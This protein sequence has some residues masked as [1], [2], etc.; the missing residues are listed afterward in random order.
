MMAP[1]APPVTKF[2]MNSSLTRIIRSSSFLER[3]AAWAQLGTAAL[4]RP[5][6][7]LLL[8][9][10]ILTM[11]GLRIIS[12]ARFEPWD[13]DLI[14]TLQ[15][16]VGMAS[17]ESGVRGPLMVETKAFLE[18]CSQKTGFLSVPKDIMIRLAFC[19]F[20]CQA[21][22]VVYVREIDECLRFETTL[23]NSGED[24]LFFTNLLSSAKNICF[25]LDSTVECGDG[26]NIYYSNLVWDRCLAIKIDIL[27]A[28]KLIGRKIRLS[29]ANVKWYKKKLNACRKEL[30]F[31]LIR[32]LIKNPT[33]A[34]PGD[35][36]AISSVS[37]ND[38]PFTCQ[39]N[40]CCV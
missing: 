36:T 18:G 31:H 26:I 2:K 37:K 30:A 17:T 39:F 7:Q 25:D 5:L 21:S 28:H 22:T 19:E 33:L 20:P 11:F 9:S 24:V 35:Q 1:H 3:M 14:S 13:K 27:L 16:T 38:D 15:I 6:P 29:R 4:R 12:R 23:R 34:L 32:T 40:Q 8:H 10:L